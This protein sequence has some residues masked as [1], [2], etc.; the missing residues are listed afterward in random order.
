M[1]RNPPG[2][3]RGYTNY[4]FTDPKTDPPVL[5]DW[6]KQK[7]SEARD[8]NGGK[9]TLDQTNDPV[10]TRCYP[11]GVPRVYFHPYPFEFVQTPKVI[12]LMYEYD[13]MDSAYIY[14]RP[15]ASQP[16]QMPTHFG[17]A[18]LSRIGRMT[19]RWSSIRSASTRRR[20]SIVW[21]MRTA[22]Q[23]HVVERFHRVDKGSS[24]A[25]HHH[26]RSQGAGEALDDDV[27]L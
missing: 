23:L 7:F 13:H 24:R 15:P 2:S 3:N 11:P 14:G 16:I 22:S 5:T 21:A 20:G 25:R 18:L 27:L 4:T 9:Y 19:Q 10:L 26:D 6:G 1:M 17:W 8:S 12:F